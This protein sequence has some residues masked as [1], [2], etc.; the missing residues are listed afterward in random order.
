MRAPRYLFICSAGHSGSTLLDMLIGAHSRVAS[1]G[2]IDQLSK[3]IALNTL[4]SCGAPIR[5]CALWSEVLRRVGAAIGVDVLADPYGLNMGLPLASDV[6]DRAH[7]TRLYLL[8]R[9]LVLGLLYLQLRTG[10]SFLQCFTRTMASAIDNNIL[11]FETVRAALD[12]DAIVDSSKSYLKAV[13]L[14]ARRPDSVRILLLTRDG[15][16]VL[17]SNLRRGDPRRRAIREWRHQYERALPLLRRYVPAGHLMQVRYE[18]LTADPRRTLQAICDFAGLE[19]EP[20]MLD[21]RSRVHHIA[22]GNRMRLSGSSQISAASHW[23]EGLSPA[24]V[25]YF[26]RNAGS[27]N[28]ELGYS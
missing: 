22:N 14:Y 11:V 12:A 26:E 27:L 21:W 5:E 13:S 28:R 18:D 9:K 6:V 24:D 19:F 3:N 1:L 16:A 8:R 20:A 4:C 17:A 15:R 23:S 7:Q 2:E 10:A 25:D